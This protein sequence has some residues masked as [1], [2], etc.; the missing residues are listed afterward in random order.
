LFDFFTN[1]SLLQSII[2]QVCILPIRQI[3]LRP[4]VWSSAITLRA[5]S[6]SSALNKVPETLEPLE[7]AKFN[8]VALPE[9]SELAKGSPLPKDSEHVT[10]FE[11]PEEIKRQLTNAY[12]GTRRA[13]KYAT[14]PIW[15]EKELA[16][17]NAWHK[18]RRASDPEFHAR[19]TQRKIET[20]Y[21]NM[22]E[23]PRFAINHTLRNWF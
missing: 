8:Y 11:T 19:Q 7:H 6:I 14:D 22:R 17:I 16:R 4:R 18:A 3:A 23:N 13:I 20:Y 15:R 1:T 9:D 21:T 2:M 12:Q 5:L 10:D